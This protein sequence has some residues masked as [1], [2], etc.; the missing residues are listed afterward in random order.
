MMIVERPA[1]LAASAAAM[2]AGPPP[3]TTTSYSPQS[4]VR[5][6]GSLISLA[7]IAPPNMAMR[8]KCAEARGRRSTWAQLR[9]ARDLLG[10]HRVAQRL[11]RVARS[12]VGLPF[13]S[14]QIG[15]E[16]IERAF[17]IRDAAGQSSVGAGGACEVVAHAH[18]R[19]DARDSLLEREHALFD[20]RRFVRR[21]R[22]GLGAQNERNEQS[23]GAEGP[24]HRR[25]PGVSCPFDS[26]LAE[27]GPRKAPQ[28][29]STI[30]FSVAL[31]R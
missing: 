21:L 24:G 12:V 30:A 15:A 13:D 11:V 26:L 27:A 7:C 18:A 23:G 16:P 3:S 5:R 19:I 28:I 9:V 10:R 31:G 22:A 14:L 6:L 2:P 29:A 8:A 17:E 4:G 25:L 20:R 1:R